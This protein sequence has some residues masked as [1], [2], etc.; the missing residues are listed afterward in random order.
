MKRW[1]SVATAPRLS[2]L[3]LNFH[4]FG[5]SDRAVVNHSPRIQSISAFA[6]VTP[7]PGSRRMAV[8]VWWLMISRLKPEPRLLICQQRRSSTPLV[9]LHVLQKSVQRCLISLF[10]IR[11]G[12]HLLG[13]SWLRL[14]QCNNA[15]ISCLYSFFWWIFDTFVS[16]FL[17]GLR[18]MYIRRSY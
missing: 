13:N 16:I 3:F 9:F 8:T 5:C 12:Q 7:L 18:I 10:M 14:R 4:E 17:Y 11:P 1:P 15:D 2:S 6:R